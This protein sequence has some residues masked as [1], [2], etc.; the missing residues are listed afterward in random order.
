MTTKVDL[1]QW[2]WEITWKRSVKSRYFLKVRIYWS[3]F[4]LLPNKQQYTVSS[5]CVPENS[6]L[7]QKKVKLLSISVHSKRQQKRWEKLSTH[8]KKHSVDECFETLLYLLPKEYK[9]CIFVYIPTVCK[10]NSKLSKK[11]FCNAESKVPTKY[12]QKFEFSL[13]RKPTYVCRK[14]TLSRK[15]LLSCG[16]FL[17]RKYVHVVIKYHPYVRADVFAPRNTKQIV[18][19]AVSIFAVIYFHKGKMQQSLGHFLA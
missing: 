11:M 4:I 15:L 10:K 5:F 7:G 18:T 6:A 14:S 19:T 13:D 3:V 16:F 12:E 9:F 2:L 17:S 1:S 8:R